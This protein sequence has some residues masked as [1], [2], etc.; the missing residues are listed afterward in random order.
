MVREMNEIRESTKLAMKN[1]Q[2]KAKYY[3]DNRRF[4]RELKFGDKI[5]LKIIPY[6]F[7][8]KFGKSRKLSLRFCD[9]F[10]ILK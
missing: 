2:D 3:V 10:K 8:L 5:F 1:A 4:C 9:S 7:E 6:Q